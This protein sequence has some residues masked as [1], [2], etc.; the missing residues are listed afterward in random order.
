MS[1]SSLEFAIPVPAARVYASSS[2][3]SHFFRPVDADDDL[4]DL[5]SASSTGTLRDTLGPR[6]I[7]FPWDFFAFIAIANRKVAMHGLQSC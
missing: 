5:S 7:H 3:A 4:E 2:A 6:E 1:H